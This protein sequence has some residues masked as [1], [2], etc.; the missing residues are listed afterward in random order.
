MTT[1][2]AVG[3]VCG[4]AWA[5]SFRAYMAEISGAISAVHWVGTFLALLLPGAII[6]VALGASAV[7]DPVRHRRALHWAA[8]APLL[9]A[10]FPLALP[11]AL[12]DFLTQGLGGGALGVALAAIAGGYA[13]GGR[14]TWARWTCGL[15]AVLLLAGIAASVPSIAGAALA[16]TTPRG[17]WVVV[18]ALSLLLVLYV[19]A[20]IPFRRLNAPYRAGQAADASSAT[21]S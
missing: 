8:S 20:A 17:M 5:A 21:A 15:L 3:G 18:L 10:A 19:A 11:G 9:F 1:W 4:L 14:R 2:A 13:I 6:G 7:A 16:F 12:V